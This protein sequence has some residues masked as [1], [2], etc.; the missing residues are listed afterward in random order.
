M[1]ENILNYVSGP[2]NHKGSY[3]R[4]AVG[5]ESVKEI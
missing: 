3:K 4:E 1:K 2:D 5:L